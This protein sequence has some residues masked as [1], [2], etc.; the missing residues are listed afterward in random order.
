MTTCEGFWNRTKF[1]YTFY[2]FTAKSWK[3]WR[4]SNSP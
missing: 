2:R 3:H 4:H 1:W